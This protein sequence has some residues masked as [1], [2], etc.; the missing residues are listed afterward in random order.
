M[1]MRFLTLKKRE[2]EE[3]KEVTF[4]FHRGLEEADRGIEDRC[5]S[6]EDQMFF[7]DWLGI[8]TWVSY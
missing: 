1:R 7:M 2:R 6:A 5:L 3:R 4:V 8:I